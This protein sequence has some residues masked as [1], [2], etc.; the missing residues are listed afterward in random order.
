MKILHIDVDDL[1]SPLGGGQSRRTFE[2]NRRLVSWG[3]EVTVVT[4]RYPGS[5]DEIIEGVKYLRIG[6]DKFPMS[7]VSF[8]LSLRKV[9]KAIPHDLLVEDFTS[10][11]SC[12]F[13]SLWTKKPVVASAQFFFAHEMS[14]KYLIPFFLAEDIGVSYFYKNFVVLA[15]ETKK[16]ILA[17]NKKANIKVLPEGVEDI[18]F[19]TYDSGAGLPFILF[20][21][22]L[23]IHQK[24]IDLLLRSYKKIK[25]E[26]Q[27]P[28]VIAGTGSDEKRMF[29]MISDMGLA[30]SVKFV[31]KVSGKQKFALYS[32]AEFVCVPSRY[33]T[34]GMVA[35]EA[36]ACGKAIIAFDVQALN[37]VISRDAALFVSPYNVQ[38][39]A[40]AMLTLAGNKNLCEQLGQAGRK[41]AENY[42]WDNIAKEQ[43]RF[44]EEVIKVTSD[45]FRVSSE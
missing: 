9:V 1:K 6:R 36:G 11:I 38:A 37:E 3:H 10:P 2:I 5:K 23:D 34:F 15:A 42:R 16:K 25:D 24:G 27:M 26:I 40:E 45:E 17:K 28:L 8:L 31:G 22:R 19:E 20:L 41:N 4:A 13:T 33:E 7:F 35:T 12:A 21:G 43:E 18:A 29:K 44:Y 14:K 39:Y 32:A 30:S